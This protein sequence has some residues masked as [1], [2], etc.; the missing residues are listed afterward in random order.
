MVGL[1]Y[2]PI[3]AVR[4]AI[5]PKANAAEGHAPVGNTVPVVHLLRLDHANRAATMDVYRDSTVLVVRP[6]VLEHACRAAAVHVRLDNI[7][8]AVQA[9]ALCVLPDIPAT[10][11]PVHYVM[12]GILMRKGYADHV[13]HA[14]L[15]NK[16][17]RVRPV[18]IQYA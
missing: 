4:T 12:W 7:V 9:A 14:R 15:D 8:R 5:P 10:E 13:P 1:A 17:L 11:S 3:A 2:V 6:T 16:R 18:P